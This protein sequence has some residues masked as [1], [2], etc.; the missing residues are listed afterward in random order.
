MANYRERKILEKLG[1]DETSENA[2]ALARFRSEPI[3]NYSH[4]NDKRY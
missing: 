3:L 1:L 4:D 2:Q